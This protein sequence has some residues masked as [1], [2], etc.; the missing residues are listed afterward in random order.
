LV[1]WCIVGLW[2]ST[3]TWMFVREFYPR[4]TSDEPPPFAI[5]LTDE[6]GG[7]T[8]AW[9]IL[10]KGERVGQALSRVQRRPDRTFDLMSEFKFDDQELL[11]VFEI[12]RLVTKYRITIDGKLLGTWI[13]ATLREK[14]KDDTKLVLLGTYDVEL[15]G[16]VVDDK[17]VPKLF[18]RG[19]ELKG[20]PLEPVP[21]PP[22]G[23]VLNPMHLLN[24]VP[25][26][27]LGRR[28]HVPL[29]DPLGMSLPAQ[30]VT[31]PSLEAEV[32]TGLLYWNEDYHPCFKIIYS[33]RGKKPSAVTWV[34]RR[35]SLV[36]QQEAYHQGLE[37]TLVRE[38]AKR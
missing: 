16:R 9:K 17:I 7:N 35:D 11:K 25:N 14:A 36:L 20:L 38:P 3:S 37:M 12:R 2:L 8:V 4:L 29:L 31:M 23:S 30:A 26:L 28:W 34:R 33:E 21:L 1:T 5:D 19:L 24:K 6:V 10:Q 22:G 15:E 18:L 13:K 27:K 32:D